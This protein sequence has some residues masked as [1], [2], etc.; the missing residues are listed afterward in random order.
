MSADF[1]RQ[2]N[3][4]LSQLR[5]EVDQ[6]R[7]AESAA[8]RRRGS[9]RQV[10]R[11][12]TTGL[13]VVAGVGLL[14]YSA[15]AGIPG[16]QQITPAAEQPV[17]ST[18]G[19]ARQS[20]P[21]AP[22]SPSGTSSTATPRAP[23]DK[24]GSGSPS[25]HK[26]GKPNPQHTRGGTPVPPP[27]GTSSG[28]PAD[29]PG[30]PSPPPGTPSAPPSTPLTTDALLVAAEMPRV[31]DSGTSWSSAGTSESEG[32]NASACQTGSLVGLG[33]IATVRRDYTWGT[34]GTVTG[35]N[36]V[37]EFDSAEDAA[38]AH[39]SFR[40]WLDGCGWGTPHGPTEVGGAGD[41]AAWWWFGRETAD[42]SGEIEVVGLARNGTGLSV[43]VWREGG[44]DL[45]YETDPM[46]D[47]LAAAAARLKD[48]GDGGAVPADS[49]PPVDTPPVDTPP[50]DP[51]P[52]TEGT[53]V[54]GTTPDSPRKT[55]P[56][57]S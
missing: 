25:T 40:G 16:T 9:R 1:E 49:P 43:V 39:A 29:T 17:A 57:E 38:D 36:L 55:A 26:T 32:G 34:E 24:P 44:Q 12:A 7:W 42:G 48:P 52:S 2:V 41:A 19:A 13:A 5:S 51:M 30:V 8:V 21:T 53:P 31:N 28:S 11:A 37:G 4:H 35:T 3:E 20:T 23:G 10:H 45:S 50:V 47:P 18:S 15:V 46:A 54:P 33:A 22:G 56:P 27:T 6:V 14:G